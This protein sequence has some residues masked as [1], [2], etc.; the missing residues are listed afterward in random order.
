MLK[1]NGDGRNVRMTETDGTGSDCCCVVL[2][3]MRHASTFSVGSTGGW[4]AGGSISVGL[5]SEEDEEEEEEE[6]MR[7]DVDDVDDDD[8]DL[9]ETELSIHTA[10]AKKRRQ[11]GHPPPPAPL[12]LVRSRQTQV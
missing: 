5:H 7:D 6:D 10:A 9:S 2:Q 4:S 1:M 8:D 11:M 12:D 3:R